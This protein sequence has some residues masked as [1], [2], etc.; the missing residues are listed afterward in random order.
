MVALSMAQRRADKWSGLVLVETAAGGPGERSAACSR[1]CCFLG[2][3]SWSCH[4][5]SPPCHALV[6]AIFML[7]AANPAA[8]PADMVYPDAATVEALTCCNGTEANQVLFNYSSPAGLAG[9]CTF[10]VGAGWMSV[11]LGEG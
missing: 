11:A 6:H 8:P 1:C 5:C 2:T 4:A 7:H 10:D 3:C 9:A